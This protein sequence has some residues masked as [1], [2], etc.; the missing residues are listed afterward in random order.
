MLVCGVVCVFPPVGREVDI[1]WLP[2]L[3]ST[4][5][6]DARGALEPR[7]LQFSGL[8][9]CSR[10]GSLSLSPLHRDW[11]QVHHRDSLAFRVMWLVG[12]QTPVTLK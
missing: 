2:F 12:T 3:V 4:S 5:Y 7:P 6:A 1:S 9:S 8:A 11:L 10:Q